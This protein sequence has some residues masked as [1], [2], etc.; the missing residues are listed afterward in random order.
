MAAE[1]KAAF[2]KRFLQAGTGRFDTATQACQAFALYMGLAPAAEKERALEVF[3]GD[4][5]DTH[6]GHLSTGIFGTKYML[7]VLTDLGRTD[8]AYQ[9]VNQATFPG[10]GHMLERGATTLW[11]HWEFSDNTFSQNHPMFGSVSEWFYKALAGINP[12]PDAVG[13]DKVIISPQPVGDLTWVKAGYDSVRGRIVSDWRRENG[14]F[15]L[16]VRI[17]VGVRATVSLPAADRQQITESGKAVDRATGVR[18]QSREKGKVALGI[19][20]GDYTFV[21]R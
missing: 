16:H 15:K 8:V 13:F 10:W 11:E 5:L 19:G 9:V 21:V 3:V 1:I 20:S 12:A 7:N 14:Q 18:F 4:I 2:N 6:K 17:P